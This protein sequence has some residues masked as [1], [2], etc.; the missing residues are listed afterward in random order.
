MPR[1]SSIHSLVVQWCPERGLLRRG[2]KEDPG[3]NTSLCPDLDDQSVDS[4]R[5]WTK[6]KFCSPGVQPAKQCTQIRG[7]L[8][9]FLDLPGFFP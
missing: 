6:A 9:L 4:K 7:S 2:E 5:E 8:A 1:G 3:H